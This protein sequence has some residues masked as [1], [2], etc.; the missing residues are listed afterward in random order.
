MNVLLW[1]CTGNKRRNKHRQTTNKISP[2]V[3]GSQRP[4]DDA[5]RCAVSE[6]LT[7]TCISWQPWQLRRQE[8][9]VR[10]EQALVRSENAVALRRVHVVSR[11]ANVIVVEHNV[12]AA[13]PIITR[14]DQLETRFLF[15]NSDRDKKLT[16][17]VK[18][19][20]RTYYEPYVF[21]DI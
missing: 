13:H 17:C 8:T 4:S 11:P 9:I 19:T 6:T 3:A 1:C 12:T 18:T 2:T 7:V 20:K 5:Q 10:R 16:F 15:A 14:H 21:N